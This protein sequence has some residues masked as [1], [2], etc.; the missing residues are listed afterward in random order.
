MRDMTQSIC[1]LYFIYTAKIVL[2][3]VNEISLWQIIRNK[4]DDDVC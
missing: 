3:R 1:K 4:T 2:M